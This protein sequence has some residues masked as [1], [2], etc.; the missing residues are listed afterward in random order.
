MFLQTITFFELITKPNVLLNVA[1]STTVNKHCKRTRGFVNMK[2]LSFLS[3]FFVIAMLIISASAKSEVAPDD[4]F[5]SS[6]KKVKFEDFDTVRF[7]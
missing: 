7:V 1:D 3:V 4:D 6:N 2:E 5:D